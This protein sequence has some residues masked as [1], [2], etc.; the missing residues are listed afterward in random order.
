MSALTA[1]ET[2]AVTITVA[3]VGVAL[4]SVVAMKKGKS[5]KEGKT[6]GGSNC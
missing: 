5:E 4:V 1:E 2:S 3:A 6:Q